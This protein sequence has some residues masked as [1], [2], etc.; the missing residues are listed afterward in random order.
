VSRRVAG[1]LSVGVLLALSGCRTHPDAGAATPTDSGTSPS[2]RPTVTV[3]RSAHVLTAGETAAFTAQ[4]GVSLRLT[5][6]KPKVSRGRLSHSYGYPPAHGYYVTFTLTIVNT[7]SQPVDLGPPNFHVRIA[8]EGVVT[9]YDGNAPY[10]GAPQQ[11]DSTEL[12]PG[13]RVRAPLTFDVRSPN[14]VLMYLPDRTAAV[15]WRF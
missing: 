1:L 13:D 3:T 15:T 5:A 6:S 7:G 11:L 4:A 14:G 2:P 10:S 8:G 9:A 12:D